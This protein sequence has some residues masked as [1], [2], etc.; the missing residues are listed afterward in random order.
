MENITALSL[1]KIKSL[2]D[3]QISPDGKYGAYVLTKLSISENKYLSNIYLINLKSEEITP[4]TSGNYD[5]DITWLNS[6]TIIFRSKRLDKN[7]NC[8]LS[9][10]EF[11]QINI[12]GGEAQILATCPFEVTKILPITLNKWLC[13]AVLPSDFEAEKFNQEAYCAHL[14]KKALDK[15]TVFDE[16][17][18]WFN[19]KGVINKL[20]TRLISYDLENGT[21]QIL[22]TP[23]LNINKIV[24]NQDK[25]NAFFFGTNYQNVMERKS[26]LYRINLK[27]FEIEAVSFNKE[28]YINE[29]FHFSDGYLLY[30]NLTEDLNSYQN[31]AFYKVTSNNLI[32]VNQLDEH[33]GASISTDVKIGKS[34]ITAL[35]DDRAYYFTTED[36][37]SLV[38]QLTLSGEAKEL[39]K[40]KHGAIFS[41]AASND[42]LYYLA[43]LSNSL[44]EVFSYD[45]NTKLTKQLSFHNQCFLENHHINQVTSIPFKNRIAQDLT[46][47][48]V[49]P[50]NEAELDKYPAILMIRGGPKAISGTIFFHEV[51]LLAD[52]DYLVCFCNP[53][54][55]DG[56]GSEFANIEK[57]RYGTYDYEDL[58]DFTDEIIKRYPKIDQANFGVTGGSYGGLMTNL[59]IG[60]THRFK[61]ALSERSIANYIT[62]A[63]TT[64]IGYYH[65]V[66]QISE[67][68]LWVDLVSYWE[69]S[70]LSLVPNIKT[71]LFLIHADEDYRCYLGDVLQFFT[72]LKLHGSEVKLQIFHQENHELS[73]SGQPQNRL[74]RL[75][76]I[77]NWWE[78][79][80][81]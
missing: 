3:L 62:K 22:S 28:F 16:L 69:H 59:I 73:R 46:G 2:S 6:E 71:P 5:K 77:L 34:H 47:F 67:E 25:N 32:K 8:N 26:E 57:Q 24:L 33:L 79:H 72:A 38:K 51:Q 44:V 13:L 18:F 45:F 52:A 40:L 37:S 74:I 10:S 21:Y 12:F 49:L 50:T 81:K 65:N 15:T 17:P 4:L 42:K 36:H 20:R 1:A 23:F 7:D 70:P 54:G 56:K 58:M 14:E 39:F 80:L 75:K 43:A 68:N 61:A 76:E 30:G 27:T 41:I 53:R 35:K 48:V 29:L 66:H 63:L 19:G 55:S 31:P 60:K 11:Y 78:K 64:D 9:L